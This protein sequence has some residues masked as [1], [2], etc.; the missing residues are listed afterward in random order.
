LSAL[1]LHAVAIALVPAP[2]AVAVVVD[3]AARTP[4]EVRHQA[5]ATP[6]AAGKPRGAVDARP[7][8]PS[9]AESPQAGPTE[10]PRGTTIGAE[11]AGGEAVTTRP[12]DRVVSEAV[13]EDSSA[14]V[15]AGESGFVLAVPDVAMPDPVTVLHLAVR[16]DATGR[17]AALEPLDPDAADALVDAVREAFIGQPLPGIGAAAATVS[18]WHLEV[19][20]VEGLPNG[21]WRLWRA[22]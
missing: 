16:V 11:G 17:V 18:R 15:T 5:I 8:R 6:A 10:V 20:F 3:A 22:S 19:R 4:L 12:P 14:E 21:Q 7:Q 9:T 2:G 1:A 13:H